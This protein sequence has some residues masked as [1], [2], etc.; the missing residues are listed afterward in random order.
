MKYLSLL[1][2][3]KST[4]FT[5]SELKIL[6]WIQNATQINAIL[7]RMKHKNILKNI[8]Y[9]LW[10][11]QEYNPLEL[12]SKLTA[13]SYISLESVLQKS[14]IIFQHYEKTITLVSNNTFTKEIDGRIFE[15][16]KIKNAILTNPIGL[17][18]RGNFSI[19]KPERALCDMVYLYK[20]ITFDNLTSLDYQQ[21]ETIA[22][23]YPKPTYLLI[24]K[25]IQNAQSK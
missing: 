9:G 24:K 13:P 15:Y 23:I 12:A 2:A 10:V 22:Q 8:G 5:I 6:F 7:Q 19:A 18:Y 17:E 11:F 21:L 14:G 25:L 4:V 3:S 16:H 1:L 20:Q